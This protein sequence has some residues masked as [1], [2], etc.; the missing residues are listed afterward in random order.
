MNM[1]GRRE[2][3]ATN[4]F[5]ISVQSAS[6]D[7]RQMGEMLCPNHSPLA[8][9]SMYHSPE[10]GTTTSFILS[11]PLIPQSTCKQSSTTMGLLCILLREVLKMKC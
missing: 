7:H 3:A 4:L 6:G 5:L 9:S 1:T 10:K 11:H 8:F 2:R